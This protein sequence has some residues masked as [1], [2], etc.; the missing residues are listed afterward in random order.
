MAKAYTMRENEFFVVLEDGMSIEIL[1][2]ADPKTFR[3]IRALFLK[4]VGHPN[5]A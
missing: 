5:H 3:N 4:E 1:H 2:S